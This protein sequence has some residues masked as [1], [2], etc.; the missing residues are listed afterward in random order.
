MERFIKFLTNC[1][2]VLFGFGPDVV[3]V[4]L[5][6]AGNAGSTAAELITFKWKHL[7]AINI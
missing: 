2:F 6:T 4:S 1:V 3:T 7:C 5:G